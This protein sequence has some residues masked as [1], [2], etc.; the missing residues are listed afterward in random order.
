MVAQVVELGQGVGFGDVA[1]I[2]DAPRAATIIAGDDCTLIT[3]DKADYT[4]VIQECRDQF[5]AENVQLLRRIEG[6]AQ[7]DADD[8]RRLCLF[9]T[10]STVPLGKVI[11]ESG[12]LSPMIHIIKS[13]QCMLH[14]DIYV[15]QSMRVRIDVAILGPGDTVGEESAFAGLPMLETC[16]ALSEVVLLSLSANDVARR[17]ALTTISQRFDVLRLRLLRRQEYVEK[18]VPFAST[19]VRHMMVG[20]ALA[21]LHGAEG[22]VTAL[23]VG[24]LPAR[25]PSSRLI[26]PRWVPQRMRLTE[27]IAAPIDPSSSSLPP[28][29]REYCMLRVA[30][31]PSTVFAICQ[32]SV[33]RCMLQ[34]RR[35]HQRSG[36]RPA[37]AMQAA[38]R[39]RRGRKAA[40]GA[41]AA[42]LVALPRRLVPAGVPP[43]RHEIR[44]AQ[45]RERRARVAV[46]VG[47][48]AEGSQCA[49]WYVPQT[50]AQ[51]DPRACLPC[52]AWAQCLRAARSRTGGR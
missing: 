19:R 7:C 29:R 42:V 27:S 9:L 47:E 16:T 4:R 30:C 48:G 44:A 21:A 12:D 35:S 34:H 50:S 26:E 40:Q 33:V 36:R 32:L 31:L 37:N 1:L 20:R 10:D 39:T 41:S 43:H 3:V 14:R 49:P 46:R 28:I 13:G 17:L 8:L 51:A 45:A 2:T 18:H 24:E 52:L 25:L 5:I 22:S 15:P 38:A 6:F 23:G 11:G